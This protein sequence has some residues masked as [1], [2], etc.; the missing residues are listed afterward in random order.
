MGSAQGDIILTT[1]DFGQKD[2]V[3]LKLKKHV[4]HLQVGV[5]TSKLLVACDDF[6]VYVYDLEKQT[7]ASNGILE[8]HLDIITGLDVFKNQLSLVTW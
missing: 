7:L 4:R 6:R 5:D 3:D 8:G 2:P 1:P